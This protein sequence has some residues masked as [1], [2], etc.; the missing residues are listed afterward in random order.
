MKV[1]EA[2]IVLVGLILTVE[3]PLFGSTVWAIITGLAYFAI[4]VPKVVE[5]IKSWTG[6][7][8]NK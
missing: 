2:I 6:P 8:G 4:Q 3:A 5:K 7:S 1:L